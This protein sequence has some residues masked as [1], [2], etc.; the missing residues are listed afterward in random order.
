[1]NHCSFLEISVS[2][3]GQY[4]EATKDL[5]ETSDYLR[6]THP[7]VL[8]NYDGESIG[9]MLEAVRSK[10]SRQRSA[11]GNTTDEKRKRLSDSVSRLIDWLQSTNLDS[12]L[13]NSSRNATTPHGVP[14][15]CTP[16]CSVCLRRETLIEAVA[17]SVFQLSLLVNE[18]ETAFSDLSPGNE[19]H[20][21]EPDNVTIRQRD[22]DAACS[23][24]SRHVEAGVS[25]KA[26]Q[27]ASHIMHYIGIGIVGLFALQ[28]SGHC[29]RSLGNETQY[30]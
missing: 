16:N 8:G 27:Q 25:T 2:R 24:G 6:E 20:H 12:F 10:S 14:L 4:L 13:T 9:Y 17:S 26:I 21:D 29:K 5:L 28:V 22:F 3:T 18:K 7:D 1:M 23:K 11:A 19:T 15:F 30:M